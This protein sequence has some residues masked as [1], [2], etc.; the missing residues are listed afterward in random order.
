[1]TLQT[2]A[3]QS[4]YGLIKKGVNTNNPNINSKRRQLPIF[5]SDEL[6]GDDDDDNQQ[7]SKFNDIKRVNQQIVIK[8]QQVS[9]DVQKLYQ[10]AKDI[11]ESIYDYDGVYDSMKAEASSMLSSHPLSQTNTTNEP[12]V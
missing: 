10:S 2:V 8:S 6:E 11:D 7:N 3:T 1:M 9:K 5:K 12:P 4:K